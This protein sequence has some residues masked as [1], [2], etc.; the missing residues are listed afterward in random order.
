MRSVASVG[1]IITVVRPE[2]KA[3]RRARAG[4]PISRAGL[5]L[6]PQAAAW[7]W[8]LR[9]PPNSIIIGRTNS[10]RVHYWP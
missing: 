5:L 6:S 1:V 10:R 2:R 9:D 3:S 8:E 7:R 4:D